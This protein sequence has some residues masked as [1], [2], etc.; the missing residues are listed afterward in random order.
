MSNYINNWLVVSTHLKNNSQNRNLPPIGMKLKTYL[1]PPTRFTNLYRFQH[2]HHPINTFDKSPHPPS[3]NSPHFL[4]L[5]NCPN[6]LRV[7]LTWLNSGS[8]ASPRHRKSESW[9][10]KC[11]P[12]TCLSSI[13][14]LQPSKTKPW[15]PGILCIWKWYKHAVSCIYIY[16]YKQ[17]NIY[18]YYNMK[19]D[20]RRFDFSAVFELKIT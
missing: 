8:F 2:F 1:N 15:V 17:I 12:E 16:K 13:F 7:T 20:L 5:E 4:L 18:I 9:V 19:E 10:V 6:F 3:K 11:A 14:G